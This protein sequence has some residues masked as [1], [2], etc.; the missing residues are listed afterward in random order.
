MELIKTIL[1]NPIFYIFIT[2]ILSAIISSWLTY[3]FAVKKFHREVQYENKL[4]RYLLLVEKMRCFV[5]PEDLDDIFNN[6]KIKKEFMDSYRTVW[7]YGSAEVIKEISGFLKMI[8]GKKSINTKAKELIKN[9]I[10]A[11]RKDLK[12]RGKLKRNDFDIFI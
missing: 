12:A 1:V 8:K 3:V 4:N 2:A 10:I 5:E 6:P 11:M 7:L 9:T